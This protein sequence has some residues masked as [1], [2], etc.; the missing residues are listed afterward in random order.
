MQEETCPVPDHDRLR[1]FNAGCQN[2]EPSEKHHRDNR[3]RDGT[4]DGSDAKRKQSDAERQ[5]PTPVV[6]DL[7]RGLD[8]KTVDGSCGHV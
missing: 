2:K 5:E 3:S 4:H 7:G 8:F 6:D 1:D